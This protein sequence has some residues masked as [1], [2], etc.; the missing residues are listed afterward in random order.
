M[1]EADRSASRVVPLPRALGGGGRRPVPVAREAEAEREQP[2][3]EHE[4]Q[5]VVR[6]VQIPTGAL[7]RLD[8]V[9]AA[10]LMA[11]AALMFTAIWTLVL[12]LI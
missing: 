1:R 3:R 9:P 11:A 2:E 5:P 10:H 4:V 6:V 8:P 12:N 7:V